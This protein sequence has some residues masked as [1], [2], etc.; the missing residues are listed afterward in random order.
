MNLTDLIHAATNIE[1]TECIITRETDVLWGGWKD[2]IVPQANA[3]SWIQWYGDR[4]R[5]APE[6]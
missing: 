6:V 1:D 2:A 4:E 5:T 3:F